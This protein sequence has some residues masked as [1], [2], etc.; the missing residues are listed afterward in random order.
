MSPPNCHISTSFTKRGT[1]MSTN[2]SMVLRQEKITLKPLQFLHNLAHTH[3][4]LF[5]IRKQAKS[6]QI[7][8]K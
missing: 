4:S 2:V 8:K 7:E 1:H 5:L 3:N 6:V